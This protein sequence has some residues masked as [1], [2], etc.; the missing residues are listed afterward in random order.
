MLSFLS[1]FLQCCHKS[2]INSY[3]FTLTATL[4]ENHAFGGLKMNVTDNWKA[5]SF[6]WM[7]F[8][9]CS[10][11]LINWKSCLELPLYKMWTLVKKCRSKEWRPLVLLLS[12]LASLG[13]CFHSAGKET[14]APSDPDLC[15]VFIGLEKNNSQSNKDI[16]AC[17]YY[18]QN[19]ASFWKICPKPTQANQ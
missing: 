1:S 19:C 15:V 3:I 6:S 17:I 11:L 8:P 18:T 7:I 10:L 9:I 14:P 16:C 12:F 13:R 5:I 2:K 4:L